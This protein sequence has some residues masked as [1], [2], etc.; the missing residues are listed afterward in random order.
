MTLQLTLFKNVEGRVSPVMD[1]LEGYLR[2]CKSRIVMRTAG[3]IIVVSEGF[4]ALT[5]QN[6]EWRGTLL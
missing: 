6:P 5:M 1:S 2:H 4:M 3:E